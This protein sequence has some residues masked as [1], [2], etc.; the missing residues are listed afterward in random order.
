MS[1]AIEDSS[2]ENGAFKNT[3]VDDLK[4]NISINLDLFFIN[5][6]IVLT[7]EFQLMP[8]IIAQKTKTRET[9]ITMFTARIKYNISKI[10]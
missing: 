1:I 9:R 8:R 6:I 2:Q 4:F 3:K 5:E 7:M 10:I